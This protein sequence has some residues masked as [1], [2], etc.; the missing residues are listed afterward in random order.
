[1]LLGQGIY[2]NCFLG[3]ELLM[4]KPRCYKIIGLQ[5]GWVGGGWMDG[6]SIVAGGW[7]EGSMDVWMYGWMGG[8]WMVD[9][10]WWTVDGG[11]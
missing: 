6:G 7:I 1:M 10:G 9:G 8:W 11:W 3:N 5:I 4:I 2:S